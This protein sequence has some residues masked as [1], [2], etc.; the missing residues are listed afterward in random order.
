[1]LNNVEFKGEWGAGSAK[2]RQQNEF[3]N[4][5]LVFALDL[6]VPLQTSVMET[7]QQLFLDEEGIER[8]TREAACWFQ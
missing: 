8:L 4:E 5:G 6:P 1:M 2:S 3:R 7:H